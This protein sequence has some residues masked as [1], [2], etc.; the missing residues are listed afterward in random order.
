MGRSHGLGGHVAVVGGS[1][2]GLAVALALAGSGRRVTVLERDWAPLPAT[3]LEAFESWQRPG[4]PQ[5]RHAHAFLSRL[6]G[7]LR[8]RSPEL[9]AKLV[10]VGAEELRF[11]DMLPPG[12]RGTPL[13]PED[14]DFTLLAC[15]RTTFEWMLRRHILETGLAELRDGILVTG[16]E[17]TPGARPR[18]RGVRLRERGGREQTLAADLVID[19]SGRRSKL[20]AWLAALGAPELRS[21][22]APCG[23]FYSS[24]FYKL[25]DG[26]TPPTQQG[27]VAADLGYL[28]YAVFPGDSHIFSVTLAASPEDAP[29]RAVRREEAF[30]AVTEA[31]PTV[32]EWTDPRVS[33]PASDVHTLASLKG[34]R[35][36]V[37]EQ[38]E[39]VAL[40]VAA[41]GDALIHTN[42]ITGRGCSLAF[43][44]AWLL[45]DA[46]RE[47]AGDPRDLALALDAAVTK[48]IVP[49]YEA[50]RAQDA[51][52]IAV[53]EIQRRGGDPFRHERADGSVDPQAWVRALV[54][55]GLIPALGEDATV[56][57]AFLRMFNLLSPP[58]AIFQTPEIF[59][60]VLASFARRGERKPVSMGPTRDELLARLETARDSSDSVGVREDE[61]SASA[62]SRGK[63]SDRSR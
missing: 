15:R 38:G 20:A 43:V 11:G 28:K 22:S 4:A 40:G 7:L 55:D 58:Q 6:R 1:V 17:G 57:R 16:L 33:L 37:V 13:L 36:F 48:E 50:A 2:A 44:N 49:W 30:A 25:R 32:C 60:R 8:D 9:L 14:G 23:I 59:A 10:A 41:V 61:L 27:L 42:P 56:L 35:R 5:T 24:R 52:A 51:D 47:H 45:A 18:I 53:G 54:R 63:A 3:P 62:R 39:P 31:L 26:V 29:L 19:A 34:T 46:L 12:L 21:E